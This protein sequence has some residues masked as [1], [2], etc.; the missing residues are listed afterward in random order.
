MIRREDIVAEALSWCGTPH[1][2]QASRKGV[3]CDC[4]GL[5]AGVARELGM[6]EAESLYANM[7][8]Y[9]TLV[10]AYL[11]R[12]GLEETLRHTQDPQPGDV[13]LMLMGNKPQHLGIS[14]F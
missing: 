8:S 3:G 13:I 11:L 9:N 5:V 2:W 7:H 1:L 4:K 12:R 14:D 6:P 10:D